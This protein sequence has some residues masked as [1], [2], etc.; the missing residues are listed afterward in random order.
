MMTFSEM[1]T[2]LNEL[3]VKTGDKEQQDKLIQ[4]S[5]ALHTLA[6]LIGDADNISL[7]YKASS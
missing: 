7:T 3:A 1:V 5:I 2:F 4:C 6:S